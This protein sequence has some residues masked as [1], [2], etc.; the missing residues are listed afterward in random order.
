MNAQLSGAVA[1]SPWIGPTNFPV[2]EKRRGTDTPATVANQIPMNNTTPSTTALPAARAAKAGQGR[3]NENR[4]GYTHAHGF[5]LATPRTLDRYRLIVAVPF[6]SKVTHAP[7]GS[8]SIEIDT[9][10][11]RLAPYMRKGLYRTS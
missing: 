11:H 8:T 2:T 7:I 1:N 10:P 4:F 5:N 6:Y 9:T 3:L